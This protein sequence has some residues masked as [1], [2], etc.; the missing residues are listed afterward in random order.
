MW[1]IICFCAIF[2]EVT[3]F[4]LYKMLVGSLHG[5][6]G[7]I[8]SDLALTRKLVCP[9]QHTHTHTLIASTLSISTHTTGT[10]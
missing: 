4:V 1:V 2:G 3:I 5:D 9:L 7:K 10:I 8:H 6:L